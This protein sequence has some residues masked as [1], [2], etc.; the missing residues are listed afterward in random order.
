MWSEIFTYDSENGDKVAIILLDTQG[1]F[2][3]GSDVKEYTTIFVLSTMLSSVQ[4]YN[5]MQNI[6]EDDLQHLQLFTEYGR[7]AIDQTNKKPFQHLLFII[8]DWQ[9]ASEIGYGSNGQTVI[10]ELITEK[11]ERTP[12]MHELRIRIESSFGIMEVFL[13]PHPGFTVTQGRKFNGDIKQIDAEF[14]MYV[15]ELTPRLFAPE[16]L[17]VKKIN[18]QKIR[19]R[20]LV[21][22]L[23]AYLNI[24]NADTLPKPKTIHMV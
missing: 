21:Q 6:R 11:N 5:L 3:S 24:F 13:M 12:E 15:K 1:T 16:N 7:L 10:D 22:Y 4:C 8:R 2:D 18:G 9:Y 14:L 19:A 23:Q 20:D 17:S